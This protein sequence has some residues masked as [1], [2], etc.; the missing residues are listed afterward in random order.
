MATTGKKVLV[1]DDEPEVLEA[2]QL[3]IEADGHECITAQDGE[4]AL[5]AARAQDPDLIIL[6]VQMPKMD[7]FQVFGE[8]RG[9][10]ATARIPV[11]ML[12]GITERTGLKF[13]G[14]D[15]ATFYGSEPEAYMDKPIQPEALSKKVNEL[16]AAAAD[17]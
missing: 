17:D 2:L 10:P 13:D 15:V 8:L 14:G 7:G 12:T 9:E 6:D 1:A 11:I 5:E 3:I 16:I 4:A